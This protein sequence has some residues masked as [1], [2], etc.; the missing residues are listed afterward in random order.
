MAN[1]N[2]LRLTFTASINA[3]HTKIDLGNDLVLNTSPL[4]VGVSFECAYDAT[5][6]I[7][8]A[9]F[10]V[11]DVTV[12]GTTT[13][14]GNL[15]GGFSLSVGDDSP[16]ILGHK[17]TATATWSVSLSNIKP[18]FKTCT[19]KHGSKSVVMIKQGC[20]SN[21]MS[22]TGL[23]STSNTVSYTWPTFTIDKVTDT[24]QT[25]DCEIQLC[26]GTDNCS[27][28]SECPNTENDE[29]YIYV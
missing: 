19:L 13:G 26:E 7:S 9:D 12:S 6:S 2:L 3:D 4:G 28:D 16:V 22:V 21:A 27:R 24:T 11:N 17:I 14:S 15:Q 29:P 10:D 5:I 23:T 18:H 1:N 25:L 20:T 8:S